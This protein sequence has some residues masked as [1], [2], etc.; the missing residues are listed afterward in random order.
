MTLLQNTVMTA[1]HF[2]NN[3][4]MSFANTCK[5]QTYFSHIIKKNTYVS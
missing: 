1:K 4:P 5:Q 3:R 2:E